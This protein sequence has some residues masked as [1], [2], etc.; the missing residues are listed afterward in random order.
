MILTGSPAPDYLRHHARAR[1]DQLACV[2]LPTGRRWSYA[3]LDRDV[4]RCAAALHEFRAVTAGS[5]V[6]VLARNGAEQLLV[7]L[8]C[9]RL[10]AMF[11]PLNWRLAD[12]E[13]GELLADCE[14]QLLLY[15]AEHAARAAAIAG[16][17]PMDP[18]AELDGMLGLSTPLALPPCDADAPTTILYTSGTSG[19]PKGVLVTERNAFFTGLN[20]MTLGAVTPA[21]VMLCDSPMFHVIGL[22]A[23]LRSV[24]MQGGTLLLS[25]GFEPETT[26]A[27]LGDPE[28]G[29]TH[30][31]CVPQM[32]DR[33]RSAPSFDPRCLA[34]LTALFTGGAPNPAANVR[35]WLAEGLRMV[36]GYGMTEAG[37]VLGMPLD[38]G[39]LAS[40]AGAAG[41][42]APTVQLRFVD[43]AGIDV[44]PG[45]VGELVLRGPNV[46]PGYW[47][48]PAD[49]ASAFLEGGWY[50]SGDLARQ[51]ADGYVTIVGRSK[52][53]YISGGENVYPVE[54]EACLMSH[55]SVAEAAVVG[56]ADPQWGE[57]GVAFIVPATGCVPDEA[58]LR[59]H[60]AARI[61]RYK[62]AA[63]LA[64]RRRA[65]EDR[66][67]QA[68]EAA[69]ARVAG[70]RNRI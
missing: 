40:K 5:R 31:F 61:A 51:D 47:R 57:V 56:V 62:L 8:A 37:T 13:L 58:G 32:A 6:A 41:L 22:L 45:E 27:R 7:Y 63:P 43:A 55:P 15:D 25:A 29:V 21:S 30:Y 66:H 67:R 44:A 50:R 12:A 34:R 16:G 33:L 2:D 65:A 64:V 46:M 3:A 24:L 69:T 36:D 68:A 9:C 42:A 49:T 54:V 10:A 39:L 4:D 19:R 60:A 18:L 11:V 14:P 20:F 23:S 59:A 53:M 1:P 48:R 52:D 26:L 17:V 38:A 70:G 35:R 28:L